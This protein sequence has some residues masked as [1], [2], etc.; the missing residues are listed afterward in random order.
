MK[1]EMKNKIWKKIDNKKNEILKLATDLIKIPSENPPGDMTEIA[2]FITN[3]LDNY[4][5]SCKKYEPEKGRIN[6]ICNIGKKSGKTLVFNG[7]MDVVPAGEKDKWSFDPYAGVIKDGFILGRGATDMKGGLT[8]II[9]TTEF[10]TEI[11]GMLN[12]ELI[13]TLV[14]DEETG[15]RFG[16]GWIIEQKIVEPDACIIAEPTELTTIDIGQKGALW[17][18][19]TVFGKPTHGSLAPYK[20]DSAI[21]KACKVMNKLL[22]VTEIKATPS[23]DIA[24][25]IEKS[26]KIVDALIGEKGISKILSSPSVNIGIIK[27]GTKVNMVPDKCEIEIDMRLPIGISVSDVTRKIRELL[28][29]FGDD[30][31]FT[32][33]TGIEPNYTSPNTELVAITREN[34]K[35]ILGAE[36]EIF[37]QWASSDARYFRLKGIPTIHYGPAVIEGIHGYNEKVKA[38]DVIT[39]TK[40]YTGTVIDFLM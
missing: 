35:E 15:G 12:G 14:P 13:L 3:H 31:V 21:L 25:V 1:K 9:I 10:L 6:L 20:G 16:T 5:I 23:E 32:T 24:E 27:G 36:P 22:K 18:K 19:A 11:E 30:V 40:V 29:E 7:H 34:I 26:K 17:C 8:G 33:I 28:A 38:E 4:G 2:N 37:V 39:A